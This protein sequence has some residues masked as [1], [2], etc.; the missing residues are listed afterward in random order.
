MARSFTTRCRTLDLSWTKEYE[1]IGAVTNATFF[2]TYAN[3]LNRV[4]ERPLK[5]LRPFIMEAK[6]ASEAAQVV[7][8]DSHETQRG[9][10]VT[11]TEG[12]VVTYRHRKRHV[13]ATVLMLAQPHGV[14][15]VMSSYDL[16]RKFETLRGCP[17]VTWCPSA[18]WWADAAAVNW[19]DD[20]AD[21]VAFARL[22][23][24]FVLVNNGP[25]VVH[26]LF[27]TTLPAGYYCDVLSGSRR[28]TR[29]CSGRAVRVRPDGFAELSVD[30]AAEVP[31]I[32]LH[33]QERVFP[34]YV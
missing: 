31:A 8:V 28:D 1:R 32:A 23:R 17:S 18:T 16:D 13:L 4:R 6:A 25:S 20:D 22:H 21:A 29:T 9:V 30:P 7:Y 24:G 34:D 12:D 14:P 27:N 19:W 11:D 26:G 33:T 2:K 10:D 15:R 5:S 3:A